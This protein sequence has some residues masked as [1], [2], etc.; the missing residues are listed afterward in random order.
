MDK[1]NQRQWG[2]LRET[3]ELAIKAGIDKD[4]GVCRTGLNEYLEIIFPR[5]TWIHDKPFG[6][7]GGRM[8]KIRPDYLCD[9]LKLIVEFDGVQHYKNPDVIIKDINN[10][11]IYESFGYKVVRIPYFIQ[12]TNAVVQL[13]FNKTVIEPLF[14]EE[15]PSMGPKGRNTPAYCCP[16]GIKRMAKDFRIFSQQYEVNRKA[17]VAM[18]DELLSGVKLLEI[19]MSEL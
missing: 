16:A 9:E 5:C 15:I 18:E 4:T 3:K 14:P 11:S 10:Q 7:H 2:F 17:L 13:L 1:D 12:L 8:Y 19:E 6:R